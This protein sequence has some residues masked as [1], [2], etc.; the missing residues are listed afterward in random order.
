[1]NTFGTFLMVS[2][3][4]VPRARMKGTSGGE[5]LMASEKLVRLILATVESTMS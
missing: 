1:M 4:R 2:E 5:A 3:T